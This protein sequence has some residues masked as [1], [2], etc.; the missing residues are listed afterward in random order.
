MVVKG[1][2]ARRRP[3]VRACLFGQEAERQRLQRLLGGAAADAARQAALRE[4]VPVEAAAAPALASHW[5]E[6]AL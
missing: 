3:F 1:G 4:A 5:A 2:A 6:C